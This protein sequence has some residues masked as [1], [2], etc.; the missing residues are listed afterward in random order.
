MKQKS[1]KLNFIMNAMLSISN[2]IFPLITFPYVSRIILPA[3]TG[4]VGF[5]TSLIAYFNIF[6]Q[7]GIPTYGIK[8]CAGVRDDKEKLTRTA[9]ELLFINLIM[10]VITYAVF[11]LALLFIPGLFEDRL[12]YIITSSTIL[13]TSLGMEWLYKALEQYTYITVRSVIFK[14]IALIFM[15]LLVREES[16]YVWY[17]VVSIIA[18]SAS[19]LCNFVNVYK[20]IGL[21]PVGGYN[22]KRHFKPI[23]LYLAMACATTVY[24]NLDVVMLGMMRGDTEVG[25]YN[26]AVKVKYV[27]LSVVTSLAGVLLPRVSYYVENKMM[28][29]FLRVTGKSIEFVCV[30]GGGATVFFM[31]LAKPSIL[32][33]S[34]VDFAGAIPAMIIIMPTVLL[35]GISNILGIQ[36]MLP[37]GD[38][39]KLLYIE[40]GGA[41]IDLIINL[42]V[43]GWF[44]A[45]G[46]SLGTLAAELFVT[47]IQIV[48]LRKMLAGEFKK[49]P[50]WKIL[51]SLVVAFIFTALTEW[52]VYMVIS[53]MDIRVVEIQ[54]LIVL[55]STFIVFCIIY[56]LML[57]IL[58]EN[59]TMEVIDSFKGKL[60]RK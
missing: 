9:H 49:I 40:I 47:T 37:L 46:A 6:A 17:G 2:I 15:F 31:L 1:I 52:G 50:Y 56:L 4:R 51:I 57:I 33:L 53:G 27:V 59:I 36:V 20:Y 26:A 22:L 16:D 30:L 29:E 35:I 3:G 24:T 42:L 13:L 18:A 8:I 12:L 43:I 14:F 39:K 34:G 38:E 58:R 60:K 21:K 32:L 28:D 19:N 41:V 23:G 10:N 55:I 11:A 44:G 54:S 7:L 45:S 25:L 5:A 48:L